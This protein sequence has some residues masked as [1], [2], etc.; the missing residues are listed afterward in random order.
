MKEI[1]K[2]KKEPMRVAALMSGLGSNLGKLLETQE[3]IGKECP[4]RIVLVF[5]DVKDE[6]RCNAKSVAEE[7]GI[8]YYC[9]DIK[10]YYESRGKDRKDMS[11]RKDYDR[12]T[13][14]L[15]RGNRIDAVA[16]CGYRSITTKEIFGNFL[17]INVHPADLRILD[18][19]GKR[20]YAGCRGAGCVRKAIENM[21]KET[22]A[23]THIV[24]EDVDGGPILMVSEPV[25]ID[26]KLTDSENLE[27]LKELGDLKIYPETLKRLAEG[28]YW[29]DENGIV[30][31]VVQEKMLLREG[32]RKLREKLSEEQVK[33][34]SS[35]I[36]KRLLQ[37]EEYAKANT[38]MFYM[39]VNKEVKTE[40][41]VKEALESG[42]KVA[43]PVSDL[44]NRRITAMQLT[45]LNELRPGA[46]GIPEP[47]GGK[48][49]DSESIELVIVPGLAFD[50]K[51]NRVGYG[52]GFYDR[53]LSSITAKKV[54]LAH[55]MQIVDRVFATGADAAMDAIVTEKRVIRSGA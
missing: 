19:N 26:A 16:M 14:K 53:F 55:E 34:N 7:Y 47:A 36:A 23:T 18:G 3:S 28:N 15:L 50:G 51:G 52:L 25:R 11:V 4:F 35:A 42:K 30:I 45:S 21:E 20:L 46:Y 6:A 44:E 31:D 10:D 8:G 32:M 41:A 49:V 39:G 40:E 22:R 48:E 54:A 27:R 33:E 1:Y 12:E 38:V 24:T 37:L 17:T 9:N 2:P 13:A 43:V 29:I 5:S